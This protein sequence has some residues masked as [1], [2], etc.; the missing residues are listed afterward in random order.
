MA[1]Q[2]GQYEIRA[3]G[4]ST[5]K[6]TR[7]AVHR[8]LMSSF[9]SLRSRPRTFRHPR[10]TANAEESRLLDFE[11]SPSGGLG[12]GDVG[13]GVSI[14]PGESSATPSL[15]LLDDVQ[16]RIPVEADFV[17]VGKQRGVLGDKHGC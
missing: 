5:G 1:G 17:K 3:A 4:S 7:F 12:T 8:A 2:P 10:I 13:G 9:A 14:G 6:S 11:D 16:K 15:R